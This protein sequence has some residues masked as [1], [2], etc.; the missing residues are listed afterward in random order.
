M[1]A[2]TG[3]SA[4]DLTYTALMAVVIAVCSW[5]TIPIGAVP[6]TMQTF[7]IFCALGLLGGMRGTVAVAVY[8][9]IGALGAPVFAG[10]AAGPSALA[11]A[12]GGY[13]LGFVVTGLIYWPIA[14]RAGGRWPVKALGM[15]L[16]LIG[17]YAFG[18][19]WFM[20]LYAQTTGPIGLGT[21]LG[22]CVIPFVIPDLCKL[23][24]GLTLAERIRRHV[25]I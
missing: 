7:G 24:L 16:G 3:W 8:V 12:T 18:T 19:A 10:F 1:E 9:L 4:R 6:F 13:I 15:A 22:W 23:A 20:L 11:S 2:R 14:A 17:C 21:A 5:V 25:R